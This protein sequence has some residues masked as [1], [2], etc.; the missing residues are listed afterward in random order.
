MNIAGPVDDFLMLPP[1]PDSTAEALAAAAQ[2]RGMAVER[3]SEDAAPA[4]LRGAAGGHL[5]GGP[6][7]AAALSAELDLA[8][9][10]PADDWLPRLPAEYLRR[11]VE[12]TSLGEARWSRT[13]MFVKQPRDKDLPAGVYADGSRLPSTDR[14]AADTPVLVGE[15]VTFVVEYRLFVLDATVHAVSRYATFGR[16][17]PAPLDS[18]AHKPAVLDFAA[19]LLSS[20]ADSLPSAVVVDVGL[21]SNA[22]RGD[23]HWAVVEA[24]MAWFSNCYAAD[25]DRVLDVVLRAA[26]PRH[27]LSVRD[28]VFVRAAPSNPFAHREGA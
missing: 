12:L 20:C 8:L 21:T 17:D 15:I 4:R 28:H 10:E 1:R 11:D 7:F 27:R 22:D 19:G 9:L 14:L 13:P 24:N 23:E 6:T 3:C 2:R 26:G 18:D 5:Y 25:T 16:L